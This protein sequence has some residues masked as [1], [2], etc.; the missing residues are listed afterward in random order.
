LDNQTDNWIAYDDECPFC[1]AYVKRARLQESIGHVHLYDIR[2][3]K[4]ISTL[5]SDKGFDLDQ[6]MVF[7]F[8]G[9]YFHGADCVNRVAMLT[10]PVGLFNKVNGFIFKHPLLSRVLYPVLRTCRNTVLFLLGKKK[11][12]NLKNT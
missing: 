12:N 9:E 2:K 3:N 10:S 7:Y 4:D 6:G 11:I 5:L 1:A 8:N